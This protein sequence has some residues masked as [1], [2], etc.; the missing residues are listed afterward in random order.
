MQ[1]ET[2]MRYHFTPSSMT[3]IKKNKKT[4]KKNTQITSVV[5][6]VKKRESLYTV[7]RNLNWCSAVENS[8]DA[9]RK[10]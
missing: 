5:K 6:D 3:T 10:K 1:I 8:M 2:T 9:S 4:N 7:G